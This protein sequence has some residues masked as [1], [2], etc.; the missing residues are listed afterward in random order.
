MIR[1]PTSVANGVPGARTND[2]E[3]EGTEALHKWVLE[4]VV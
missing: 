2:P 1:M 3:F 4:P